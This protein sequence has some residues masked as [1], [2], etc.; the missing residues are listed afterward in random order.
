MKNREKH[1]CPVQRAGVLDNKIRRWIQNPKEILSPY[2]KEGMTV[3]DIGCGPG[4]FTIEMAE[5]VG[6]SGKVIASDLQIGMLEKIRD[7]I[8]GTDRKKRITLHKCEKDRV[9][10][11]EQV[12]FIL[13]F[14]MVHELPNIEKFFDEIKN[15]LKPNGKIFMVEPSF[16]VSKKAFENSIKKANDAGLSVAAKPKVFLSKAVILKKG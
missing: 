14:Y 3:L 4:F 15:I 6:S 1:V 9:G 13:L 5:M 16:H 10:V 8:H 12:D 2:I 11:S 7:K